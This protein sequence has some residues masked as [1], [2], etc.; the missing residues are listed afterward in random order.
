[1]ARKPENALRLLIVDDKVDDAEAIV[2]GLRNAGIAVRPVRAADAGELDAAV[3]GAADLVLV[4]LASRALP[5][6][7]ALQRVSASGKDLPVIAVADRLYEEEYD[8][9]LSAGARAVALRHRPGQLLSQV[10]NEWEDLEARRA[11]RRPR[12]VRHVQP[13]PSR[14]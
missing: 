1:M 13:Q 6:A 7:D 4:A 14:R 5:F 10:H 12:H 2:S 9:A 8:R 11:Q 3:S